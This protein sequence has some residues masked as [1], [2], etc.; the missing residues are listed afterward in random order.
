MTKFYFEFVEKEVFLDSLS[1]VSEGCNSKR[2]SLKNRKRSSSAFNLKASSRY[3]LNYYDSPYTISMIRAK[4]MNEKKFFSDK[5]IYWLLV[6]SL[7]KL[8]DFSDQVTKELTNLYQLYLDLPL[9][10]RKPFY[11]RLHSTE[12]DIEMIHEETKMKKK[13]IHFIL[14][15]GD[16]YNKLT[17]NYFFHNNFDLLLDLIMSKITQLEFSFERYECTIN[18]I[19]DNFHII[20]EDNENQGTI[21]FN[22]TMKIL[23]ILT[24]LYTPLNIISGI[25]SMNVEVPFN[26]SEVKNFNAFFIIIFLVI[27]I[28]GLLINVFKRYKWL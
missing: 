21:T 2:E 14:A 11:K 19:K 6:S 26:Y 13:F 22:N 7:E 9:K 23:T 18:L 27:L 10:E 4:S 17:Y 12:M 8:E 5:L 28:D 3:K 1:K 24:T 20:V 15:H 16:R 25:M